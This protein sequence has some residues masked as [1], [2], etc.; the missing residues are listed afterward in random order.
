MNT[1]QA[2][3]HSLADGHSVISTCSGITDSALL[4]TA[5]NIGFCLR[6]RELS[7]YITRRGPARPWGLHVFSCPTRDQTDL[8]ADNLNLYSYRRCGHYSTSKPTLDMAGRLHFANLMDV[9]CTSRGLNLHFLHCAFNVAGCWAS[10]VSKGHGETW[11][12][13]W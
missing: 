9:Q 8:H 5:V 2:A 13:K 10:C 1:A 3:A 6:A 4:R 11:K 12:N 7:K